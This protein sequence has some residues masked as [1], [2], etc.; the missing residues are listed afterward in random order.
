VYAAWVICV[1]LRLKWCFH[2]LNLFLHAVLMAPIV[3]AALLGVVQSL[4]NTLIQDDGKVRAA[5]LTC[6]AVGGRVAGRHTGHL[7]TP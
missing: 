1:L 3:L 5:A 6:L 4:I 2:S 7:L